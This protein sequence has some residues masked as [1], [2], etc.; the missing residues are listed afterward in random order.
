MDKLEL[1][2]FDNSRKVWTNDIMGQSLQVI[3]S[4]MSLEKGL[5]KSML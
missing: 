4:I 3:W 1:E 2:V 5:G